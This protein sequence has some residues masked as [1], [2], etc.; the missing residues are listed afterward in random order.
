[1]PETSPPVTAKLRRRDR[2]AAQ[3][4][5]RCEPGPRAEPLRAGHVAG[6]DQHDEQVHR[7]DHERKQIARH[8][9]AQPLVRLVELIDAHA[10][11]RQADRRARFAVGQR[12]RSPDRLAACSTTRR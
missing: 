5:A 7:D 8:A 11:Q 6:A 1:M 4:H 9:A 10:G 3:R 2:A 12:Q